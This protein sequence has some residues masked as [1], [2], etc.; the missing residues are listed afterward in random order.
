MDGAERTGTRSRVRLGAAWVVSAALLAAYVWLDAGDDAA[1]DDVPADGGRARQLEIIEVKPSDP[2]PGSSLVVTYDGDV[3][4]SRLEVYGGKTELAILAR[5]RGEVVARLP[6]DVTD[7]DLKVRVTV[8]DELGTA[9]A[10]TKRSKPFHV[11]VRPIRWRK[12][13]RAAIGGFALLV[14]GI[15]L[16]TRGAREATG[17]GDARKLAR[18]MRHGWA[19]LALGVVVGAA[20]QSTTAAAGVLAGLVSSSVLA[21]TPAALAFSGSQLGAL[22]APLALTSLV[23]PRDALVL[24]ALGVLWS[25]LARARRARA[26]SRLLLGAGL[27]AYGLQVMRP[28]V[29]PF[30]L[31]PVLLSL[32]AELRADDLAATVR[33]A[34]LGAGLVAALQG[35][36]AVLVLVLAVAH[37]TGRWDLH[38]GFA[39][40]AG[41]GLGSA[42]SALLVTPGGAR[43]RAFARANLALGAASS[44]LA[45]ASAGLWCALA[46]RL[47]SGLPVDAAGQAWH[48]R[49]LPL[50]IAFL[51]SQLSSALLLAPAAAGL[52]RTPPARGR[53]P[54]T[55]RDAV[56]LRDTLLGALQSQR[57]ALA[58]TFDLARDGARSAGWAGE[59]HL[60]SAREALDRVLHEPLRGAGAPPAFEPLARI[61]FGSIQ[62]QRALERLLLEVESMTDHRLEVGDSDAAPAAVPARTDERLLRELQVLMNAGLGALLGSLETGAPLDLDSAREREMGINAIEARTRAAL[63]ADPD[64]PDAER[65]LLGLLGVID[66]YESAGNQVYRLAEVLGEG[67]E[68]ELLTVPP[69]PVP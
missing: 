27:I 53:Q 20:T 16:L 22:V 62:L 66:A 28:S 32:G 9:L 64:Q 38:T 3:D 52:A 19:A 26:L 5:R 58:A 46:E 41:T 55:V 2:Y 10:P 15:G 49:A 40:L 39:L 42:I 69:P 31:H 63:R 54:K 56:A 12:I 35:P 11:R 57:A 29:E 61:A 21:V 4:P 44:A 48:A 50:S 36:T 68:I 13:F 34:L 33:C 17:L 1:P 7:G 47:T 30:A 43:C 14:L 24:V 6:A 65:R 59:V 37:T 67:P 45:V 51:M 23:A 60:E 25:L 8:A 18:A